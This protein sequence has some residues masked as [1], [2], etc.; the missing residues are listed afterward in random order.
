M[1]KA[2]IVNEISKN[3]GIEKVTVQKT[4]EALMDNI[5]SSLEN[6][7][8]VYLRGFG[9]FALKK[10]AK[11]TARNI[12]KNTSLVIPEHF[13]PSFKP[14]KTFKTNVKSNVK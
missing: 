8:N 10:R 12:S 13:I 4:V 3:T 14:A 11:K 1:T 9:S 5:K 7:E 6:G 2:D